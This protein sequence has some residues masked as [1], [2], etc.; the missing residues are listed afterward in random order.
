[1]VAVVD[2]GGGLVVT[3]YVL[4]QDAFLPSVL[5]EATF[6]AYRTF[7]VPVSMIGALTGLDLSPYA[8]A[9][10]LGTVEATVAAHELRTY[11]EIVLGG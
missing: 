2:Q 11:G 6:G 8:A 5:A 10:P 1:M 9:D 3:G 7:Q 4:G